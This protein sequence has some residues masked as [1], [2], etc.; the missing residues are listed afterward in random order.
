MQTASCCEFH[1][2]TVCGPAQCPAC[3][4][5]GKPVKRITLGAL[6]KPEAR[7][8]IPLQEEFCFCRM[9][10]CEIVYFR[11]GEAPF[12]KDDLGV[13]VGLK[14]PQDPTVPVCYCFGW[15][16]QKIRAEIE[17][18]GQSTAIE[19]IKA[20]VKASN[21]YCEVTNPQGSCCLGNVAKAVQEALAAT[22]VKGGE[23]R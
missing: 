13:R 20:Q 6:L 23:R 8:R 14:E 1:P 3:G 2:P 17:A 9:A 5:L 18:T 7:S 12:R 16:P 10:T 4:T 21:C 15:T 11:E 19:Q 22:R